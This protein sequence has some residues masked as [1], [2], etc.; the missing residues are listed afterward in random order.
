MKV[1]QR[2][3]GTQRN[4]RLFKMRHEV[5]S[6]LERVL[7]KALITR[8][9]ATIEQVGVLAL[10]L[11]RL[12]EIRDSQDL[13]APAKWQD[14]H[15]TL[16]SNAVTVRSRE[17]LGAELDRLKARAERETPEKRKIADGLRA[18]GL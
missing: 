9:T 8:D 11:D 16:P 10:V 5:N 4:K 18:L 6:L 12:K 15:P 3:S 1:D 7:T 2:S 13:P 17:V 14:L